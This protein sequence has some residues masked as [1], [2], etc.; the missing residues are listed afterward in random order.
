VK[1]IPFQLCEEFNKLKLRLVANTEVVIMEVDSTLSRD[2]WKGQHT[3]EK[4]QEIK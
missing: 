2:I 1:S 4:I 3:D